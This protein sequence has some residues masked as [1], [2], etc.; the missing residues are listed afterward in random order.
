[1]IRA[2]C[3]IIP[4][5][6][7]C[8]MLFQKGLQKDPLSR[9][10]THFVNRVTERSDR[11][12]QNNFRSPMQVSPSLLENHPKSTEAINYKL[13]GTDLII[14]VLFLSS[15]AMLS[16]TSYESTSIDLA[17]SFRFGSYVYQV[18]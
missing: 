5:I 7:E 15:M 13:P 11:H 2:F 17:L 4:Q 14:C 6:S 3:G 18:A 1:M 10:F 16:R 9:A 8:F 12:A